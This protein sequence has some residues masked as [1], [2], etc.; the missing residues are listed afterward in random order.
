M[1]FKICSY[2]SENAFLE[3]G[4]NLVSKEILSVLVFSSQVD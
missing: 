4:K 1:V 3:L 2:F